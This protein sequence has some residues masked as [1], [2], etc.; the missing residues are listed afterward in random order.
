MIIVDGKYAKPT[1]KW[2]A[3]LWLS[4]YFIKRDLKRYQELPKEEQIKAICKDHRVGYKGSSVSELGWTLAKKLYHGKRKNQLYAIFHGIAD[5]RIRK[6]KIEITEIGPIE[7][8]PER[9][10]NGQGLLFSE[11]R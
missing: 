3:A 4:N 1:D 10:E 5:G 6:K 7:K 9:D 2:E 8:G 11:E